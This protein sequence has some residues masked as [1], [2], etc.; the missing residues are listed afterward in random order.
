MSKD[1]HRSEELDKYLG[2]FVMITF[3]DNRIEKGVLEYGIPLGPGM[4][5]SRMYSLN[6]NYY[7]RKSHIKKVE[8]YER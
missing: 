6:R 3:F 4:C 1:I 8:P 2:Q 7:F 5:N